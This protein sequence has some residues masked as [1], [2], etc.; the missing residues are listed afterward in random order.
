[1]ARRRGSDARVSV[2]AGWQ[3][4]RVARRTP[5]APVRFEHTANFR[6]RLPRILEISERLSQDRKVEH[7]V[8]EDEMMRIHDRVMNAWVTIRVPARG[9][10]HVG[11]EVDGHVVER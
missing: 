1:M 2:H 9:G 6:K 7:L 8:V 10:D 4:A 11:R 3:D 5:P